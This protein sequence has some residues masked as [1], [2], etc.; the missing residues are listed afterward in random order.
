MTVHDAC[1]ENDTELLERTAAS[2]AVATLLA[3][4]NAGRGGTLVIV[5]GAGLGKTAL[6]EGAAERAAPVFAVARGCGDSMET[7]IPFGLFAQV[8]DGLGATGILDPRPPWKGARAESFNAVLR[9]LRNAGGPVLLLLDDLH[10][11]DPASLSLLAFLS[12]RLGSCSVAVIAALRTWPASP[13]DTCRRLGHDGHARIEQLAPLSTAAAARLLTT[14][15]GTPLGDAAARAV[16]T[17]CAGNPL[18]LLEAAEAMRRGDLDADRL[19]ERP[20]LPDGSLVLARFGDLPASARRYLSAAAVLGSRFR[21]S[22]AVE[23]ASLDLADGDR[24]LEALLAG[25]LVRSAGVHYEF[26]H[27]LFH[28][29]VYADLSPPV[30]T[31]LH[32]RAFAAL[33]RDGLDHEAAEHALRGEVADDDRVISTLSRLG[34]GA[35]RSGELTAAERYLGGAVDLA[36]GRAGAHL[37]LAL[38]DTRLEQG[39]VA[40]AVVAYRSALAAR[41]GDSATDARVLRMLGR[42]HAARG[43]LDEAVTSY[44]ESAELATP[45]DPAAA[46]AVLLELASVLASLD[47]PAEGLAVVMGARSLAASSV[48]GLTE[49]VDAVAGYLR[50]LLG[51]PRGIEPLDRVSADP[52]TVAGAGDRPWARD[53]VHYVAIGSLLLERFDAAERIL[54]LAGT[55]ARHASSSRLVS[56]ASALRGELCL[57]RGRV[58]EALAWAELAVAAAGDAP[59]A[60]SPAPTVL[61]AVRLHLGEDEACEHW[62]SEANRAVVLGGGWS[63]QIRLWDV[64]GRLRLRQGRLA[65]A[66]ELYRRLGEIGRTLRVGEPCVAHWQR[67]AVTALMLGGHEAEAVR[68]VDELEATASVVPCRW[69]RVV[70]ASGRAAV[71]ERH[72]DREGAEEGHRTAVALTEDGLL[73]LEHIQSLVDLGGFL[74]RSGSPVQARAVLA[75]AQQ[76]AEAAGDALLAGEAHAELRIAGGRRHRTAAERQRLTR[77]EERVGRLAAL[78]HSNEEIARQMCVAVSTVKTHLE[79]VYAKLEVR[80]RQELRGTSLVAPAPEPV[81]GDGPV[82][83]R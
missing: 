72:G 41:G 34:H 55:D 73:P 77:Q 18:L 68:I 24:A 22:V 38:G 12:R 27:P 15:L 20:V 43:R 83:S 60:G 19:A 61:A 57:R 10:W 50:L 64:L 62:C 54:D 5:G 79:R 48:T 82:P 81:A 33:E 75:D 35:L 69:P 26:V 2:E 76:R 51:D 66:V 42:A 44:R 59:Q 52:G 78:G 14:R 37:L 58:E 63:A 53:L 71:A 30:R 39:R 21:A 49:W 23:V 17:A 4:A 13:Y 28:E 36:G 7:W 46:V 70:A 8:T 31:R 11:A 40:L 65:E 74:R 32:A 80:S 1:P 6:L 67:H 9:W 45:A 56:R 29:T 16:A 3:D 25:G 47:S